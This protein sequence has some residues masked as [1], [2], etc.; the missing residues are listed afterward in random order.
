MASWRSFRTRSCPCR[1]PPAC[2]PRRGSRPRRAPAITHRRDRASE[3]IPEPMRMSPIAARAATPSMPSMFAAGLSTATHRAPVSRSRQGT[4]G[5]ERCDS[6]F[7][8]AG[9]SSY[10]VGCRRKDCDRGDGTMAD[11]SGAAADRF[12]ASAAYRSRAGS[13]AR[14]ARRRRPRQRRGLWRLS[15]SLL[16]P[17]ALV[18]D[19][20]RQALGERLVYVFRHFPNERAHPGATFIARAAEAAARRA[21]LGD[22]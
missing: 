17:P 18:L 16:P 7:V 10:A 21:L 12:Q 2:R 3:S 6:R 14:R 15:L 11:E 5:G 19:R 4:G 20:L 22:A 9:R 1:R 13:C 8:Q